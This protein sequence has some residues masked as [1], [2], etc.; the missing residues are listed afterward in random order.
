MFQELFT[1]NPADIQPAHREQM[2][3]IL[4]ARGEFMR[5]SAEVSDLRAR[6]WAGE[7]G[8]DDLIELKAADLAKIRQDYAPLMIGLLKESVDVEGLLSLVPM[9]V[10]GVLQN[11]R[12]PLPVL[13]E[14]L[15]VDFDNLKLL[16]EQLKDFI[17]EE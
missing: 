2:A 3:A 8:M 12:V 15:G 17:N 16:A 6:A 13:L 4:K 14:A 7:T 1:Y 11:F 9:L 10:A 5:A